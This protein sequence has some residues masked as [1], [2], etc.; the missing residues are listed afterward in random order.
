MF[1][2]SYWGEG[3]FGPSYWGNA[4]SWL[5]VSKAEQEWNTRTRSMDTWVQT[6]PAETEWGK[7]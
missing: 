3:Y 1:P 4:P 5:P 6:D 2:K 7:A